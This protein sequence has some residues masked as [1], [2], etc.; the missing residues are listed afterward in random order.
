[1][2]IL[3]HALCGV[4]VLATAPCHAQTPAD[5]PA[6]LMFVYVSKYGENALPR[7]VLGLEKPALQVVSLEKCATVSRINLKLGGLAVQLKP[8][9]AKALIAAIKALGAP[10]ASVPPEVVLWFTTPDNK[11]LDSLYT[12]TTNAGENLRKSGVLYLDAEV[13][14]VL[15]GFL[16][17]HLHPQ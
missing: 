2:K 15:I 10:D 12:G 16:M 7:I 5:G 8:D 6:P 1:M 11:A 4:L 13:Q 3:L 9:D 14:G 17:N